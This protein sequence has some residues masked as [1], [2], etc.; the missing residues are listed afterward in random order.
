VPDPSLTRFAVRS[1]DLLVLEFVFFN[2]T[3]SAGSPHTLERIEKAQPAMVAVGFQ[4]QNA[5]EEAFPETDQARVRVRAALIGAAGRERALARLLAAGPSRVAFLVPDS[6]ASVPLALSPLLEFLAGCQLSVVDAARPEPSS[7]LGC[8]PGAIGDGLSAIRGFTLGS[9]IDIHPQPGQTDPAAWHTALE[10]PFRLILSPPQQAGFVHAADAVASAGDGRYELWHTRLGLAPG[11]EGTAADAAQRTVRAVFMRQGSGPGWDP[12]DYTNLPD[13]NDINPFLTSLTQRERVNIV[14]LT[15]NFRQLTPR[16]VT[17]ERLMLTGLGGAINSRGL[18]EPV[19]PLDVEEWIHRAA[20]GRDNYVKVVHQGRLFPLRHRASLA[21]VTERKF[22]DQAE[23]TPAALRQRAFVV[24]RE[25]EQR[26]DQPPAD[27]LGRA[28]P[29]KRISF[30]TLV[31][32]DIDFPPPDRENFWIT[33]GGRPLGFHVQCEDEVGNVVNLVVPLKFLSSAKASDPPTI[34]AADA[35]YFL[36]SGTPAAGGAPAAL[37]PPTNPGDTTYQVTSLALRGEVA[38]DRVGFFPTLRQVNVILPALQL[39]AGVRSETT[40]AYTDR[41]RSQGLGGTNAGEVFASVLNPVDLDFSSQGDRSGALVQPNMSVGGLSRALGP[42]GGDLDKVA[43]G[44]FDPASYFQGALSQAQLFGVFTLDK[45]IQAVNGALGPSGAAPQLLTERLAD[46]LAANMHWTPP[47]KR[48]PDDPDKAI[49][50]VRGG[51]GLTLDA[52]VEARGN[53]TNAR[54]DCSLQKITLR[55]VATIASF[56]EVDVDKVEFVAETGRKPDVSLQMG[57][58]R[59]VGV[60]S[61]VQTLRNLIPLS[62]FSDPPSLEVTPEGIKSTFSQSVPSVAVGMFSLQNISLGAGF[63][64]PFI[65]EPMTAEF[66]FCER[67]QPFLL[68]VSLFGGGGFFLIEVD[69]NQVHRLEGALEFGASVSIDLGVASGGVHVM[70]GIYFAFDSTNGAGLIGYF[71]L[72]GNVSVLG[73][74]SASI[75]LYL[76]LSYEFSSGKAAGRATLTV[77]VDVFMFSTSVQISCERKFA[78]SASDPT[79]EELMSP[80]PDPDHPATTLDPWAEYCEAYA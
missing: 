75:E 24:V 55:L 28:M 17:V 22:A 69:P 37:A 25:I 33:V 36:Q 50:V 57:D 67:Q 61:F 47:L 68:T 26:Y 43:D 56:L 14:H 77:E 64:L 60:L 72:G 20:Q 11:N 1:E 42:V 16:A 15:S 79:F 51:G 49:F 74:I 62:G 80:Y 45:V 54:I 41:Y 40:I 78:G 71:R 10:L 46:G 58:V 53:S 65:G 66:N 6:S 21:I 3:P 4:S 39:L 63:N 32:P 19:K 18:W 27:G 5:T 7:G 34:V 30:Q 9:T 76:A 8:I 52:R 73:L 70:A 23:G 31:T 13:P 48:F 59:F 38:S 35:D 29:F 2:L 12:N 44:T